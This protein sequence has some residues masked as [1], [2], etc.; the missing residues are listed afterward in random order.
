MG[1]EAGDLLVAALGISAGDRKNF[2]PVDWV[3][4]VMC[5]IHGRPEFHGTTYHVTSP[6]PPLIMEMAAVMQE[7]VEELSPM[8]DPDSSWN[9][10]GE[11]F[12][13]T[14]R[15]QLGIYGAY[16]RDDPQ[17]RHDQYPAAPPASA[18]PGSWTAR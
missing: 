1:H 14:F 17:V 16:W 8:A 12:A 9:M 3:S 18:L 15:D 13:K 4:A 11:W 7:V 6:H 10:D 5:H 2:V